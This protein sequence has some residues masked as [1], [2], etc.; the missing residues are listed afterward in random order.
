MIKAGKYDQIAERLAGD[1]WVLYS[2]NKPEQFLPVMSQDLARLKV[3]KS[4]LRTLAMKNL[5]ALL[6]APEKRGGGGTWMLTLPKMGG[7]FEASL[8]LVDEIWDEMSKT[9]SG[10][11]VAAA[12]ARDLLFVSGSGDAAGVKKLSS[13]AVD[14]FAKV[15]HPV[16]Q[17]VLVRR[18]GKW[19]LLAGQ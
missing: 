19:R 16:S 13:L 15:D 8:L 1:M 3:D 10:D 7:N 6:P 5:R 18:E 12:P 2:F 11:L 9:V 14:A 17:Q 4:Q